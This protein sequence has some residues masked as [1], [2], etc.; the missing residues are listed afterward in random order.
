M[1]EVLICN[2]IYLGFT[3]HLAIFVLTKKEFLIVRVKLDAKQVKEFSF[4][5][6]SKYM[7]ISI[8][9]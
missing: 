3:A 1:T 5:S 9:F 6:I 7:S 2:Q 4:E 8:K